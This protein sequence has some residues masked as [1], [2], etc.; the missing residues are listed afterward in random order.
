MFGPEVVEGRPWIG[1]PLVLLP[2]LRQW[3]VW[4]EQMRK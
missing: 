3:K 1:A 4:S 2:T